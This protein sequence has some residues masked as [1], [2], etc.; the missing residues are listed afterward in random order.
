MFV[1]KPEAPALPQACDTSD[2]YLCLLDSALMVHVCWSNTPTSEGRMGKL[3]QG[4]AHKG[5]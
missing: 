4:S 1:V 5:Y 2:S 3:K